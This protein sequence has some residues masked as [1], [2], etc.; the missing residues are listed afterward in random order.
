MTGQ[1]SVLV[2]DDDELSAKFLRRWLTREGHDVRSVGTATA[3]VEACRQ[4]PPD[5]I[6]LDLVADGSGFD[7]CRL[8]KDDPA[9]R[10]IPIVIVTSE[11]DH[12]AR[13]R[14]IDAGAD[15]FLTK[16]FEPYE[17]RARI[18]ALIRLKRYTDEL[19][20][21][22]A[23]ILGL[24]ATIEARDP[25]T[26]GHCQRLAEYAT[27]LG[28][29]IGLDQADLSALQRG[30]FLHDVGKIA[31]PDCVL[32]KEGVLDP[33][34]A[35]VMREHPLVGDALCAGL[36]SLK[37][38]RPIVRHHH[39][40]LDGTGYP[41]GLKNSAVPLLAQIVAVVDVFDALTTA[42]PYRAAVTRDVAVEM[43]FD[44]AARGWRDRVLV[45]AFVRLLEGA[46]T[47][48]HP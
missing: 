19:E 23:I 32:L 30:G 46:P 40:R 12:A 22:E 27:A 16:P 18:R 11:A 13:L 3:A 48:R 20:S 38:V 14:G 5:L 41:D 25:S 4:A 6:L 24:G 42:R 39:E 33:Y 15:D 10:L 8:L 21:G 43:L 29:A 17:L 2:A 34:E 47:S 45:D 7:L 26:R 1:V 35:R 44:E 31:V 36:R 28:T 37:P 9:T